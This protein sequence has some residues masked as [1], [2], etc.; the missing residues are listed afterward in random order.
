MYNPITHKTNND[1]GVD[2]FVAEPE[3]VGIADSW[4]VTIDTNSP[5]DWID[6][7]EIVNNI[8]RITTYDI[9]MR[10]MRRN[11]PINKRGES[12]NYEE[13]RRLGDARAK[14]RLK[15]LVLGNF[16]FRDKFITLTFDPSK[17]NWDLE[18]I[19]E[20]NNKLRDFQKRLRRRKDNIKYII[21]PER[22]KSNRIHYHMVT[23]MDFMDKQ[24]FEDIWGYGNTSINAIKNIKTLQYYL[25]KYMSKDFVLGGRLSRRFYSSK[26]L[27]KPTTVYGD[28]PWQLKEY[29]LMMGNEPIE[30]YTVSTSFN[31]INNDDTDN[32][33]SSTYNNY[34]SK[35]TA[36]FRVYG[37]LLKKL[38][39]KINPPEIKP[40]RPIDKQTKKQLTRNQNVNRQIAIDGLM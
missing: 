14:E 40:E 39:T 33:I 15:L 22:H 23:D 12:P 25:I 7:I 36:I 20:C 16:K 5:K 10:R 30:Q 27:T 26:N 1:N 28:V 8:V 38:W 32:P 18:N 24:E 11:T 4:L 13:N 6:K 17:C 29:L 31:Y 37:K 35:T 19:D 21:V 2:N 9:P 34:G 3:R